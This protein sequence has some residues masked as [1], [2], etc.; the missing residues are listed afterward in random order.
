MLVTRRTPA[1]VANALRPCCGEGPCY[2]RRHIRLLDEVTPPMARSMVAELAACEDGLGRE[3]L[4][5]MVVKTAQRGLIGLA[6]QSLQEMSRRGIR[7]SIT[8]HNALL[9]SY[10]RRGK[11]SECLSL[12][13]MMKQKGP[14]PDE[15]SYATTLRAAAATPASADLARKLMADLDLVTQ[16][17][18]E[19]RA[20]LPLPEPRNRRERRH[21]MGPVVDAIMDGDVGQGSAHPWDMEAI[22][23]HGASWSSSAPDKT[24]P[25][26]AVSSEDREAMRHSGQSTEL[27]PSRTSLLPRRLSHHSTATINSIIGSASR[28]VN[29]VGLFTSGVGLTR[30]IY[31]YIYIY[32]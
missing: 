18:A 21:G 9:A 3:D 5:K 4:I 2:R 11:W 19:E 32:V 17:S 8:A 27:S 6:K 31:I 20:R 1:Q 15:L 25:G 24:G 22:V 29:G 10:D 14:A 7:P 12:L 26:T 16:A 23:P 13:T 28:C 30:Y